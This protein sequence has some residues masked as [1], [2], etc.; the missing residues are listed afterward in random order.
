ML[1]VFSY[2]F[3]SRFIVLFEQYPMCIITYKKSTLSI[4]CTSY[5]LQFL[6]I[7]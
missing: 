3:I 5:S 6:S 1:D 7:W 2:R 4:L